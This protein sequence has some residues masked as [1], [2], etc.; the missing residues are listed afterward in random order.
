MIVSAK[1][2]FL[3]RFGG[4]NAY[5]VVGKDAF[6]GRAGNSLRIYAGWNRTGVRYIDYRVAGLPLA[7][8]GAFTWFGPGSYG[9]TSGVTGSAVEGFPIEAVATVGFLPHPDFIAGLDTA[10]AVNGFSPDS[11]NV[12]SVQPFIQYR[13]YLVSRSK[14]EADMVNDAGAD[15]RVFLFPALDAA[16]GE[17]SGFVHCRVLP[18][19]TFAIKG[20]GGMSL[21]FAS[22]DLLRAE[23]RSVRSGYRGEALR[24]SSFA[25]ASIELRQRIFAIRI[26]PG[27]D[28]AVQAFGFCDAAVLKRSAAIAG[29]AATE[30][31]DAYGL[32]MRI[33][34]D[35]PV[36]AY[37]SF[38]YG[39]NHE[40]YSRFMFCGTAG[41]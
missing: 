38:S 31:V 16:K 30:F 37:F 27:F 23:D 35:N 1:S 17:L 36:F 12:C 39:I 40:G 34:F 19:T 29:T 20:A 41:F 32:G 18:D 14:P 15:L 26:P 7:L 28:C 24:A 9:G 25:L 3:Y 2:G 33:L 13:R 22:F 5:A 11:I 10:Y 6:G 4:G 8:G 21:G